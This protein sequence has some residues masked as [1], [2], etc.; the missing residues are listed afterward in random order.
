MRFGYVFVF[1]FLGYFLLEASSFARLPKTEEFPETR[2]SLDSSRVPF[3]PPSP[4]YCRQEM[5]DKY[6][7]NTYVRVIGSCGALEKLWQEA[8]RL[9]EHT[10]STNLILMDMESANPGDQADSCQ[11]QDRLRKIQTIKGNLTSVQD[12][13]LAEGDR[14]MKV[15][16]K[17]LDEYKNRLRTIEANCSSAITPMLPLNKKEA[18]SNIKQRNQF[19]KNHDKEERNFLT[20][21]SNLNQQLKQQ[22][23]SAIICKNSISTV[24]DPSNGGGGTSFSTSV[25]TEM[26]INTNTNT[27]TATRTSINTSINTST[28]TKT[29]TSTEK[30]NG[31]NSTTIYKSN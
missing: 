28:R 15:C 5:Y 6:V 14:I 12:R 27:S 23:Q 26:R 8:H 21:V 11:T 24:L 3:L 29:Q 4:A 17:D 30:S 1:I 10:V 25:E 22:E 9:L 7:R 31:S 19:L 13:A 18:E 16:E 2:K 20:R